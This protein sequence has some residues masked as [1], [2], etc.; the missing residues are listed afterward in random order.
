MAFVVVCSLFAEAESYEKYV[1]RSAQAPP[2]DLVGA[3]ETADASASVSVAAI[4]PFATANAIFLDRAATPPSSDPPSSDARIAVP[5]LIQLVRDW[6]DEGADERGA[7]YTP[8][9]SALRW[10][11][12]EKSRTRQPR[13][14]VPGAG[15]GRLAYELASAVDGVEVVAIDPDVYSLHMAGAM[16]TVGTEE[17]VCHSRGEQCDDAAV[18][19]RDHATTIYPAVHVTTNWASSADRLGSLQVPDVPKA[20]LLAVQRRANISLVVGRFPEARW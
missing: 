1:Q 16:L 19:P 3:L 10:P 12:I 8:V 13:V 14:L 18:H 4:T 5:L 6:S 15:Q 20:A 2:A 11:L 7:C 17:E 9:V